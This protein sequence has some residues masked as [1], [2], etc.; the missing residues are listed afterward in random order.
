MT[1]EEVIRMVNAMYKSFGFN[2]ST[3]GT[4]D[5]PELFGKNVSILSRPYWDIDKKRK[6]A[7]IYPEFL[8]FISRSGGTPTPEEL[9]VAADEIAR[10]ARLV[11]A[12]NNLGLGWEQELHEEGN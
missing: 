6:V 7:H 1:K 3:P 2:G 4:F 9:L 5:V 11:Q 8:A 10:A 12:L